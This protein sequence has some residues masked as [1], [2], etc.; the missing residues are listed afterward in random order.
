MRR[1]PRSRTEPWPETGAMACRWRRS[2]GCRPRWRCGCS[3]APSP[4]TG[5]EGPV[6]LG[7]L[8]ACVTAL[9]ASSGSTRFRRTLAGALVTRADGPLDHRARA[10]A[11]RPRR[12]KSALTIA[13]AAGGAPGTRRPERVRMRWIRGAFCQAA[14]LGRRHSQT[15]IGKRRPVVQPSPVQRA[16]QPSAATGPGAGK[17][18]WDER[19]SPQFRP[20]GHHRPAAAGAVHAVPESRPAHLLAGHL[21]L[22]A[23]ERGRRRRSATC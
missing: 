9:A 6:E 11:A 21:V 8:E 1:R 18:I 14:C 3:A 17:T 20:L 4:A 19:Q 15:Y 13:K 16:R 2:R 10:G 23:S 22:A 5:D 7:K 12:L